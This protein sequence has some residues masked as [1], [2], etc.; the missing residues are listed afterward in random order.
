MSASEGQEIAALTF[1]TLAFLR[2]AASFDVFWD[3]LVLL[4]KENGVYDPVLPRKRRMPNSYHVGSSS[5]G[6]ISSRI[7]KGFL[8]TAAFWVSWFDCKLHSRP[9]QSSRFTG[10]T[11]RLD[12]TVYKIGR[13]PSSVKVRRRTILVLTIKQT[14][15]SYILAQDMDEVSTVNHLSIL[16]DE[17]AIFR[18][19]IIENNNYYN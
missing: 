13:G 17:F 14:L 2:T 12:G 10:L 18:I 5:T 1:Q 9:V 8:P 6:L 7:S 15:S 3:H 19:I 16:L 11:E 4:Q